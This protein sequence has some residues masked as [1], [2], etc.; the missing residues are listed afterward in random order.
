VDKPAGRGRIKT[1]KY[2][3]LRSGLVLAGANAVGEGA[4]EAAL[5]DD[6]YL[7]AAEAGLLDLRGTD[8]VV[9]SACETGLG[10]VRAGSGV[11]GLRAALSYAGARTVVTSLFHVPDEETAAL[12]EAFYRNLKAGKGKSESL[13]AAER[14]LL[15]RRRD[16]GG[17]AHPFFWGAFI[18]VGDP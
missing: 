16:K 13:Y 10:D 8:L 2:P 3:L 11:Y 7:T 4:P 12:M 1:M 17:A 6:G 5:L 15:Q 9:L 18:L 14:E